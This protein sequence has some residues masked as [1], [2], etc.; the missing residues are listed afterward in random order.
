MPAQANA[1]FL[2]HFF[3]L[4]LFH[5]I[6]RPASAAARSAAE[7]TR[8]AAGFSENKTP[9]GAMG[10]ALRQRKKQASDKGRT[11]ALLLFIARL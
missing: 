3:T 11:P 2:F 10:V 9:A 4:S 8:E 6:P 7:Y 5:S 1:V